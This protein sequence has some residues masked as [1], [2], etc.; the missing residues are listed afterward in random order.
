MSKL[1]VRMILDDVFSKLL[2]SCFS[3]VSLRHDSLYK[4][5]QNINAGK[6]FI[7]FQKFVFVKFCFHN[8]KTYIMFFTDH[9]AHLKVCYIVKN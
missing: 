9:K 4:I 8:C 3:R 2:D 1:L 7:V 5:K 6:Y